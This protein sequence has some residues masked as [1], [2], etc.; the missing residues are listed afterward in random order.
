[1]HQKITLIR[2]K[3][4]QIYKI[5]SAAWVGRRTGLDNSDIQM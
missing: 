4:M 5:N 2:L 3:A 1:M